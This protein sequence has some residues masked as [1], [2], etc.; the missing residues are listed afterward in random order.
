MLFPSLDQL[1]QPAQWRYLQA[2]LATAMLDLRI[3]HHPAGRARIQ[4]RVD[5]IVDKIAELSVR[6]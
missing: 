3:Q 1:S 6:L 2:H 4:A 5:A